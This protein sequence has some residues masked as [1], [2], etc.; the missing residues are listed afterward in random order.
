MPEKFISRYCGQCER[1]Q[2]MRLRAD[3]DYNCTGCGNIFDGR[4]DEHGVSL[5]HDPARALELKEREEKRQRKERLKSSGKQ[6]RGG[7]G[8]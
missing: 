2:Q 6:L 3:G 1:K 8:R 5:H 7:T 4:P